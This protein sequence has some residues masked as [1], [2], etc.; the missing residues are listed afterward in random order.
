MKAERWQYQPTSACRR[1]DVVWDLDYA[2]HYVSVKCEV[3]EHYLGQLHG[4]YILL[5]WI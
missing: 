5:A 2:F 3:L 4:Q 1:R